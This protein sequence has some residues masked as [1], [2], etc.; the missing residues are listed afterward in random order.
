MV[1]RV[2]LDWSQVWW[3]CS[4]CCDMK[5]LIF[6]TAQNKLNLESFN[7]ESS[8]LTVEV[9]RPSTL[10]CIANGECSIMKDWQHRE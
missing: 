9:F 3:E 6:L 5:F 8:L 1:V 2:I 7:K 10:I 4:K